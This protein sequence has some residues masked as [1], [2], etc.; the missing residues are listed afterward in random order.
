MVPVYHMLCAG[1]WPWSFTGTPGLPEILTCS[2]SRGDLAGARDVLAVIGFT[3]MGKMIPFDTGGPHERK[4][5][6]ISKAIGMELLTVDLLLLPAFLNEVWDSREI[7]ELEGIPLYV[8]DRDG[9][10]TMKHLAGRPQDLSDIA[11]LEG[12]NDEA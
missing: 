3:V 11:N 8:V 6:R 4:V 9:L 2:S 12:V 10:I 5:F 7:Y 1:A